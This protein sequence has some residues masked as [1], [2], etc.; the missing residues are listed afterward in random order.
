VRDAILL[1]RGELGATAAGSGRP[2]PAPATTT[3][4]ADAPAGPANARVGTFRPIGDVWEVE[5]DGKTVT[6]RATKGMTDLARLLR[7]PDDEVHCL[8]LV[9]G[10]V[11][12]PDTGPVLDASARRA[13][14]ARVRELQADI[15]EADAHN[16]RG[17]AE[18]ARAELDALVDELTAALGIGGRARRT[19]SSSERARSAVT[20]RLR[21]TIKRIDAVHPPL[22][23]H[24]DTA[25]RTGVFCSYRPEQPVAWTL[26]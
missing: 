9:G 7:F 23:R 18:R 26:D 20:Q 25:V 5:F 1:A 22:G 17:R 4:S 19:G 2:T 21:A 10:A 12:Q 6:M 15:D 16:D 3:A 13:Y 24:L 14:E 11:D 8:E